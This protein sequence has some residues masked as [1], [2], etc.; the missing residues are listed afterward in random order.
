MAPCQQRG[1]IRR[2]V[3]FAMTH[4]QTSGC[5]CCSYRCRAKSLALECARGCCGRQACRPV[6]AAQAR[7]RARS[8]SV[9]STLARSN[10]AIRIATPR[11]HRT[12]RTRGTLRGSI[13]SGMGRDNG[14]HKRLIRSSVFWGEIK[15]EEHASSGAAKGLDLCTTRSDVALLV[16]TCMQ[17]IVHFQ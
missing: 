7:P 1:A 2:P 11:T 14:C 8:C 13:P 17:C 6:G 16:H 4:W 3:C 12:H 15:N 10:L 9:S 5:R